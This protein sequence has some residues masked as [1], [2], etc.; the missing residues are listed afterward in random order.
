MKRAYAFLTMLL[1]AILAL[2]VP[3][4]A[5]SP[6]DDSLRPTPDD[7][8]VSPTEFSPPDDGD[9]DGDDGDEAGG[10]GPTRTGPSS[11]AAGRAPVRAAGGA[12]P[13]TVAQSGGSTALAQTG[14]EVV[15][16]ATLAAVL[17]LGGGLALAL[18][19]RRS[20]A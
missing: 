5:Q 14:I 10:S 9:D 4:W 6:D 15:P 20:R 2:G 12:Q 8:D 16:A 17:L 1:V 3:A 19:R 11:G 7:T 13:V 18:A